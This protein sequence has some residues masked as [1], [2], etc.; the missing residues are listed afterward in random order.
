VRFC[1]HIFLL[2]MA[3]LTA[4]LAVQDRTDDVGDC[5]LQ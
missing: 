1:R 5:D 3:L 4:F 2:F